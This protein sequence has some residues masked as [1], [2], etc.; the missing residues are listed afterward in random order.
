MKIWN[1]AVCKEGI[2][3]VFA[4]ALGDWFSEQI[5]EAR[6]HEGL[7]DWL[8]RCERGAEVAHGA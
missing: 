1:L 8:D 5:Y 3:Y 4:I 7:I 2:T 6:D